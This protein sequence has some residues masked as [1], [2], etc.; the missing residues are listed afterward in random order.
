M[1]VETTIYLV[2]HCEV[3]NPDGILYGFLPNFGLSAKG[4]LQAAALGRFFAGKPIAQIDASPLQ[5]A[6]ETAAAIAAHHPELQIQTTNELIEAGF[7]RYLQG[8]KP[9]EVPLRRPLWLVHKLLPGRLAAD[10]GVGPMAARIRGPV[11]RM[12]RDH[13][14]RGGICVSHGD[15]IQAFWNI[16][17]GKYRF[18]ELQCKKGGMLE[19]T[20][21][22]TELV[23]LIYHSPESIAAATKVA[24]SVSSRESV[25]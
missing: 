2:R 12:L 3:E 7:S 16:A 6:Q 4:K 23:K 13:P 8:V 5:R 9:R 11:M 15:P 1:P 10:E 19:L 24:A 20:F 25:A 17:T 18:W 14:G 22:G 21:R